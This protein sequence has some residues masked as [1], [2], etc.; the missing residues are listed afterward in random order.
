MLKLVKA[1]KEW[2]LKKLPLS[3]VRQ[4]LKLYTQA[5]QEDLLKEVRRGTSNFRNKILGEKNIWIK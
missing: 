5:V 3:K 2:K 4:G 1:T